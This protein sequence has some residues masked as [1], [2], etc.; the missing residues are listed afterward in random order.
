MAFKD[1]D[2]SSSDQNADALEMLL[3]EDAG[4]E[5]SDQPDRETEKRNRKIAK[6]MR[7]AIKDN[8]R[9]KKTL[10]QRWKRNVELRLG[11]PL[12]ATVITFEDADDDLQSE[13]NPD[14]YLTKAKVANLFSQLPKV[15]GTH[16]QDQ[17][18][19][20]VF[21]FVKQLNYEIGEKRANLRIAMKEALQD[22]V[23]ASGIGAIMVDYIQRTETVPVP[24]MDTTG[25]D[26][27]LVDAAIQRGLMPMEDSEQTVSDAM[28]AFRIS[29]MDLIWPADFVGSDFDNG[30]L[31]G[32]K[33]RLSPSDAQHAFDL[34]DEQLAVAQ[35][36]NPGERDDNLRVDAKADG[37]RAA[38]RKIVFNRMFYWRHRFDK[39]EKHLKAIW[40]IVF[41]EG[42]K[43]P[44]V[45]RPWNGQEYDEEKRTYVGACK[46][47]VRIGTIDYVSDNPIVPS[48]SEAARPQ[49]NDLRR[50]RSQ[51]FQ[52]RARS[53]PL[54]WYDVN[55]VGLEI[56]AQLNDGTFQGFIP[57]NG[58]GSRAVGEIARAS[59]PA[60]DLSFDQTTH[61]DLM[62]MWGLNAMAM[63]NPIGGRKNKAEIGGI[64]QGFATN[65]GAERLEVTQW[66]LS[67]VE[68]VAGFTALYSDFNMLTQ[69]QFEAMDQAWDRGHILHDLVLN[70]RPNSMVVQDANARMQQLSN[71]LN[72]TVKSGYVNP[73]P[74]IVEMAELSDIDPATVIIDPA[75]KQPDEPQVSFRVS[76]KDD[77][78]NPLVVAMLMKGNR[79]P[80][81]QT[82]NKAKELLH[83]AAD[84]NPSPEPAPPG[85]P[86]P[87]GPGGPG[88]PPAPGMLPAGAPGVPH[89]ADAETHKGWATASKI[90]KRSRD[91]NTGG[92]ES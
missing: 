59:Y 60:E 87:G 53:T 83:M 55:R 44:V 9:L 14:W 89:P 79:M 88:A 75:P 66:F 36:T 10:H 13:I 51:L 6:L 31:V 25:I 40:E 62:E 34:T 3:G 81:V 2:T 64:Q 58:D 80:D 69:A 48:T 85:G 72:L 17:F 30:D 5:P 21:P 73:K 39:T 33:G 90:A 57:T 43:K 92:R 45:H 18:Q 54:R 41:V 91:M 16:E 76:G 68:V 4:G 46:F 29:P 23:N 37:A 78:M 74:L 65:I 67:I 22:V 1:S 32:Y 20:A 47:P 70:I 63:G 84:P 86:G 49:V 61:G 71:F 28:L 27:R 77:L 15:Q 26:P 52:N 11:R 82:I 56:Q 7:D 8:E 38:N 12:G 19:A 24:A 42:I 50:S 35:S